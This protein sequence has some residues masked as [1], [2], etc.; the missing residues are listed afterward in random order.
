MNFRHYFLLGHYLGH[1]KHVDDDDDYY[2]YI[3]V[4]NVY[5]WLSIVEG[6]DC[7]ERSSDCSL[8]QRCSSIARQKCFDLTSQQWFDP[9]GVPA[10]ESVPATLAPGP[11]TATH[12]LPPFDCS[13]LSV[14]V[15]QLYLRP[16][17]PWESWRRTTIQMAMM[18]TM[19]M[20]AETVDNTTTTSV[21][22]RVVTS[23]SDVH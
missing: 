4:H 14:S 8:L 13:I 2:Y 3:D 20:M 19:A 23:L 6:H 12:P 17:L 22:R 1:V 5:I 21:I 9:D 11:P 16:C 7:P 18:R 15:R 10:T